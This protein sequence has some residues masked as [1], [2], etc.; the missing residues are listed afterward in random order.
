MKPKPSNPLPTIRVLWATKIGDPDYMEQLITEDPAKI[1]A[2]TAWAK[3]NGFD[4]LRTS[5]DD[6]SA[7]DFGKVVNRKRH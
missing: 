3:A 6:G 4:R 5:V 2:A 1:E 7:P